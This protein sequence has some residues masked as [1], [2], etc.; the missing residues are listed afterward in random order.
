MPMI[1][2]LFF[3]IRLV[4]ITFL[5]GRISQDGIQLQAIENDQTVASRCHSLF[6][7]HNKKF[8]SG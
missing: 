6:F 2:G 7:S 8:R 4:M 3:R 5:I 1:S